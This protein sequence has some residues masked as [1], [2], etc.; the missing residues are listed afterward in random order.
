MK[1]TFHPEALTEYVE[2]VEFYNLRGVGLGLRLHTAVK[3]TI[4]NVC[5]APERFRIEF[6][7]DIR[8]IRVQ[9]FPYNIIFREVSGNIQILA[10]AHHRRQPFYWLN[11]C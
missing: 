5:K 7:P 3:T 1:H 6:S 10:I 11:R 9:G 2:H 8:K 4:A